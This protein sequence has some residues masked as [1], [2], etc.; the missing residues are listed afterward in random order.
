ML[1]VG[2]VW[3]NRS[4]P[5]GAFSHVASLLRSADITFGN[6]EAVYTRRGVN[7]YSLVENQ[8]CDPANIKGLAYAGFDVLN[9]AHNHIF[10]W[11]ITGVQDTIDGIK[12]YGIEVFG[13]GLNIEEARKPAV[14][15][16]KGNRV[17]FLGYWCGDPPE[18]RAAKGKPG[19]AYV[20]IHTH[21]EPAV[22][23][24][25]AP[26]EV[27][28]FANPDSLAEMVR[29][30]RKLR[31]LCD[32]LVV[33]LHTGL[34][35]VPIKIAMHDQ[36]LARAAIDAGADVVL[37]H[38]AH[39]L[40]GIEFYRSKP[41]FYGLCN[42]VFDH[43]PITKLDSH[44]ARAWAQKR[45]EVFGFEDDPDYPT[46]RFHPEARQTIVAKLG[47]SDGKIADVRYLPCLINRTGQPEVLGH[48]ERGQQVFDYMVKITRG[49][50]LNADY[51]WNGDEVVVSEGESPL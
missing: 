9:L 29:D 16:R 14:L 15:E 19:A 24:S 34:L 37:G 17:G 11:G 41:I 38:H 35:H 39:I 20:K 1:A 6:G 7:M 8:P 45:M 36:Q 51:A 23:L 46:Y 4:D 31:P 50:H 44:A 18:A 21:Y 40:K 48:D 26:A 28:T 3:I 10:D 43:L 2:D 22:P 30:I 5:E 25:G 12:Q 42:L 27:F 33:S 47:I 13:A 32:V 49:A